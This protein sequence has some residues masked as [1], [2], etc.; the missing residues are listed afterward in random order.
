M[1]LLVVVSRLARAFTA[2]TAPREPRRRRL[3]TVRLE[4]EVTVTSGPSRCSEPRIGDEPER[5]RTGIFANLICCAAL[6]IMRVMKIKLLRRDWI[7]PHGGLR[8]LVTLITEITAI[9]VI[10]S[11]PLPPLPRCQDR[12]YGIIA[13][14]PCD[15]TTFF[16]FISKAG[17]GWSSRA[18]WCLKVV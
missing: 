11:L 16:L 5:F 10:Q 2:S 6:E 15:H 1:S 14:T 4:G 8:I 3:S 17:R 12:T 13:P 7:L 9:I 18:R